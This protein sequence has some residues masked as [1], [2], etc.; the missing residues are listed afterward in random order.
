MFP[1]FFFGAIAFM[2]ASLI[3]NGYGTA[4]IVVII[5]L[6]IWFSSGFLQESKWNVFLNPFSV[7]SDIDPMIWFDMIFYN[8]LYLFV[9]SILAILL[10]LFNLQKRERYI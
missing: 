7:P 2:F 10:G 9:G 3:R 4:A 1:L 8:R 6:A 5:I